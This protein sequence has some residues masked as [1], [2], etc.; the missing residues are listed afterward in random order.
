MYTVTI[1]S[2]PIYNIFKCS[3]KH[4]HTT[5]W[6]LLQSCLLASPCSPVIPGDL[7]MG[8]GISP[9]SVTRIDLSVNTCV[10]STVT[11]VYNSLPYKKRFDKNYFRM[12]N[13]SHRRC[14]ILRRG[15]INCEFIL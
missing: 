9:L 11:Y 15:S 13:I 10:Y 2:V 6:E 5:D 12:F 14:I 4:M 1:I 7:H 8:T 3:T